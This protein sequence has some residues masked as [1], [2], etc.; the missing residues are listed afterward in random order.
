MQ[1]SI[2][3]IVPVFNA[4]G[5]LE[6]CLTSIM[7]QSFTDWECIIIDDGSTDGSSQICD[8][9]KSKDTRFRVFHKE[10]GGV[11]SARNMG[12]GLA[13]GQWVY[14]VD[15]DDVLYYDSLETLFALTEEDVDSVIGGYARVDTNGKELSTTGK[16]TTEMADWQMLALHF[17]YPFHGMFYGYLPI[18]LMRLDVIKKNNLLFREDIHVKE[19]GLFGVQFICASKKKGIYHT[20]PI[21]KY[22]VNPDSKG[23]IVGWNTADYRDG[24]KESSNIVKMLVESVEITDKKG[25]GQGNNLT[26]ARIIKAWSSLIYG[27]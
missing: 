8:S 14:F 12:I 25:I 19:D 16:V 23:K 6:R 26:I 17:Y 11:S 1:P 20:K 9:F 18:R 2:S 24:I 4:S 15:A 22:T 5:F 13:I 10:N 3:I 7:E 27:I 21:Y